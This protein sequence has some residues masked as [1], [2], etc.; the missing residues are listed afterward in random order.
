MFSYFRTLSILTPATGN[1]TAMETTTDYNTRANNDSDPINREAVIASTILLFVFGL[2]GNGLIVYG[3]ARFRRLRT[4]TNYFVV[5]LAIADLLLTGVLGAWII[6]EIRGIPFDKSAKMFINNVDVLCFSASMLSM[7][8][9][10]L[11]RYFAITNPLR[12]DNTCTRLR[13]LITTVIIWSTALVMFSIGVSRYVVKEMETPAANKVF[14][15][16]LTVI[17]FGIPALIMVFAHVSIFRIALK[18]Q[19]DKPDAIEM[20]NTRVKE[21]S[22]TFKIS[23]NTL[24]ILV[25]MAIAWGIFFGVTVLEAQFPTMRISVHF[26]VVVGLLPYISAA[27]DPI[28]YILLTRDLRLKLCRCL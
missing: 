13:A 3:Y 27:I 28:V 16:T 20:K 2:A 4:R 15:T 23:F 19:S 25:P 22:K 1:R 8:A 21:M 5:N 11:D 14:M 26:S 18:S 12:Y 6:E 17:N 7:T 24:V 9:V 10:S